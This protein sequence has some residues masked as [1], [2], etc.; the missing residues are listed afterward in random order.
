[1]NWYMTLTYL[2]Y[3]LTVCV[4]AMVIGSYGSIIVEQRVLVKEIQNIES[5][6]RQTLKH[7]NEEAGFLKNGEDQFHV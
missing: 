7:S 5:L 3:I 6:D 1:M 4:I 2:A